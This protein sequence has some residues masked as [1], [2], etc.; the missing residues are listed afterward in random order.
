MAKA[1]ACAC[2]GALPPA[3][4]AALQRA[5]SDSAHAERCWAFELSMYLEPCCVRIPSLTI[6]SQSALNFPRSQAMRSE[7]FSGMPVASNIQSSVKGCGIPVTFSKISSRTSRSS[8]ESYSASDANALKRCP[9]Q[10]EPYMVSSSSWQARSCQALASELGH[11]T[12][13]LTDLWLLLP[14]FLAA[15]A[16]ARARAGAACRTGAARTGA[17]CCTRTDGATVDGRPSRWSRPRTASSARPAASCLG[18]CAHGPAALL[19]PQR[20]ARLCGGRRDR[21]AGLR[22]QTGLRLHQG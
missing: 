14:F 4:S 10:V 21:E 20:S 11:C 2:A 12:L 17:A 16:G 7:L 1:Q 6:L 8:C 22:A 19:Q 3:H 9:T 13:L 15:R 18:R 5:P